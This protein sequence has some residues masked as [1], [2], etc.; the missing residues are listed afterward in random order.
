MHT[1]ARFSCQSLNSKSQY[2]KHSHFRW[3][4]IKN[5]VYKKINNLSFEVILQNTRHRVPRAF[6]RLNEWKRDAL[7]GRH[8]LW[9][10][11]ARVLRVARG[12]MMSWLQDCLPMHWISRLSL[13]RCWTG[14][15]ASVVLS[16]G[17]FIVREHCSICNVCRVSHSQ[18]HHR[19]R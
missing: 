16:V 11:A 15:G 5:Q 8:N 19:D 14:R 10:I 3:V 12:M 1:L 6:E 4:L 17:K 9:Y 13:C 2:I 7:C 18:D